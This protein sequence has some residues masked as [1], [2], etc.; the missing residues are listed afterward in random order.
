MLHVMPD[1]E[2][3]LAGNVPGYDPARERRVK[4]SQMQ[5][6]LEGLK[7]S[8]CDFGIEIETRLVEGEPAEMILKT[9]RD[10]GHVMLVITDTGMSAAK[11]GVIPYQEGR[12]Y[13]E[14]VSEWRGPL[15]VVN[16]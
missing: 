4:R 7:H 11:G 8:L 13:A 3:M 16:S 1:E 5:A 15:L 2:P 6:Y 14:V 12:V 10:S 9:A